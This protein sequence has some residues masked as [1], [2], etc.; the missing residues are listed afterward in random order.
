MSIVSRALLLS[1]AGLLLAGPAFAAV[2][3]PEMSCARYLKAGVGDADKRTGKAAS[4][5]DARVRALC[6]ANPKMK[7][8]DAE[9]AVSGD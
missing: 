1:L 7:A 4:V 8:M 2:T 6:A 5:I 9:I 3:D